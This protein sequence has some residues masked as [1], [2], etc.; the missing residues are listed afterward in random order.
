M[1]QNQ[2]SLASFHNLFPQKSNDRRKNTI[3]SKKSR[4]LGS[5]FAKYIVQFPRMQCAKLSWM[6][7]ICA[8]DKVQEAQAMQYLTGARLCNVA[9]CR[10]RAHCKS[11]LATWHDLVKLTEV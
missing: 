6:M 7:K 5:P 9:K 4:S 8:L 11:K 1:Q 3:N 10:K 2:T